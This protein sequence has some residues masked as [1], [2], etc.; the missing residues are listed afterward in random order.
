MDDQGC[1]SQSFYSEKRRKFLLFNAVFNLVHPVPS[2]IALT[3]GCFLG[4]REQWRPMCRDDLIG[5]VLIPF[6]FF[7]FVNVG[8]TMG[9]LR[10]SQKHKIRMAT[11]LVAMQTLALLAVI[12]YYTVAGISLG[13]YYLIPPAGF[14]TSLVLS[15]LTSSVG[16]YLAY[17][18]MKF[19]YKQKFQRDPS[20][21]HVPMEK[22]LYGVIIE[23]KIGEGTFGEV[24]LGKHRGT[25]C[26]CK[27]LTA[28]GSLSEFTKEIEILTKLSHPNIVVFMG[29]YRS[30]YEDKYLVFEYVKGGN[31]LQYL[32]Q[33]RG[34]LNVIELVEMAIETSKG[35]A[36]LEG[37]K[38]VHRDLAAR[39]LLV[40]ENR[41]V[42]I[43]D[44]GMSR[45]E[46][47]S[48]T[49]GKIPVKWCSP[50]M[51]MGVKLT[52]KSDS[53]SF[54]IV[55]WELFTFG[56]TPYYD[57]DNAEVA[58][59]VKVAENNRALL[60]KPANCPDSIFTLMKRCWSYDPNVRPDFI[61]ILQVLEDETRH[62]EPNSTCS[63]QIHQMPPGYIKQPNIQNYVPPILRTNQYNLNFV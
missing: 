6:Y 55:L 44:F 36:Y 32:N 42:K 51:Q 5:F 45:G 11:A 20:V 52:S 60:N 37:M 35:M 18:E 30:E 10:K 31:L 3:L 56:D 38:I 27:K 63:H 1:T 61:T 54:G 19:Q 59:I 17:R 47:Y 16:I 40:G 41:V 15:H 53:F 34:K 58:A 23:T 13:G 29:I 62:L 12:L 21:N 28:S 39:N 46:S 33:N 49:S 22:E 57:K 48:S 2:I 7:S 43:S 26:A 50:E 25:P 9:I 14:L 8:L 24:Y 4:P